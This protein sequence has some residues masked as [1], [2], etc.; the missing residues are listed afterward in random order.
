LHLFPGVIEADLVSDCSR[1][2]CRA[3]FG[4]D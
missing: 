1:C 3:D 4:R 2:D